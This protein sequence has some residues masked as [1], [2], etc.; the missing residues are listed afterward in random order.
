M[1]QSLQSIEDFYVAKGM[2]GEQLRNALAADKEYQAILGERKAQIKSK[3]GITEQE[4]GE[5][6]LPNETDY[7]ILSMI[8]TLE[9]YDLS[10]EDKEIVSLIKS[11][12]L[13]DWRTPLIDKLNKL[14]DKY[15]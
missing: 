13:D 5:L 7:Q 1:K 9:K 11:Q 15:S 12:L 14:L 10:D 3:F 4:E 6:L 8:K 2:Q